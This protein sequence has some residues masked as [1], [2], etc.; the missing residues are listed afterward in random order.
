MKFKGTEGPWH[1][2]RYSEGQMSVRNANETRKICVSRVNNS[3]ESEANL[4]LISKAPEMLEMLEKIDNDLRHG[5][6]IQSWVQIKITQLIKE[7]TE[8]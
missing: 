7:A 6:H 5:Y 3:E 8:L 2:N 1:L 4:Q